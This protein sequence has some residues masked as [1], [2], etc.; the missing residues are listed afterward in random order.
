MFEFDK[1]VE[2]LTMLKSL[3]P[4]NL[5]WEKKLEEAKS[6]QNMDYYELLGIDQRLFKGKGKGHDVFH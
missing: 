4:D 3:E 2:D 6:L 5:D 1:A